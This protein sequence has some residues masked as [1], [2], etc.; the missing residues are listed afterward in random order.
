MNKEQKKPLTVNKSAVERAWIDRNF[1]L[2]DKSLKRKG[3]RYIIGVDFSLRS[4]GFVVLDKEGSLV[5]QKDVKTNIKEGTR[6]DNLA[7]LRVEFDKLHK[8]FSPCFIFSYEMI[9]V[10]TNHTVI[11]V[12]MSA[13]QMLFRLAGD[14]KPYI[15]SISTTSLK[16]GVL[17]D[18]RGDKSKVK[19]TVKN[20]WGDE[21]ISGD[22]ADAYV[23][24]RMAFEMTRLSSIYFKFR[25]E[26]ET[27][28]DK[29]IL[30]F[31]KLRVPGLM[32]ELE[33]IGIDSKL[34]EALISLMSGKNQAK[35]N[36]YDFYQ[37]ER[38]KI[39]RECSIVKESD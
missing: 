5:F 17:G 20:R 19:E 18:G 34:A 14:K 37:K 11:P 6:Y 4:T 16:K 9:S 26:D 29:F 38:E 31:E 2:F 13:S 8:K 10:M 3:E 12:S 36:D 28:L 22:C 33:S 15:I 35:E 23:A 32:S 25:P 39:L 24:A 1:K 27:K 7:K 21:P 30:D